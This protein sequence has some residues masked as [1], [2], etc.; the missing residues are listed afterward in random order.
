MASS[1]YVNDFDD[2]RFT[3]DLVG[4]HSYVQGSQPLQF[5]QAGQND[6][7]EPTASN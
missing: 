4:H 3:G 1:P 6:L 5:G 2:S 7:T